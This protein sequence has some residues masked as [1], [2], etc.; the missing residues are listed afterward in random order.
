M[1]YSSGKSSWRDPP[2]FNTAISSKPKAVYSCS[3]MHMHPHIISLASPRWAVSQGVR[4]QYRPRRSSGAHYGDASQLL[5][6]GSSYSVWPWHMASRLLGLC[7]GKSS[8]VSQQVNQTKRRQMIKENANTHN[9]KMAL[10]ESR[11]L[12]GSATAR[13]ISL[14]ITGESGKQA[15]FLWGP[16]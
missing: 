4:G 5:S 2:S 11:A 6:K 7:Y 12:S 1:S 10:V 16:S 13:K 8:P 3:H 14:V 9:G 15:V